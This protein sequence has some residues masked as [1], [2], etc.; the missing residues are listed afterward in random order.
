MID[1]RDA[2]AV[3]N[4]LR[5]VMVT[6]LPVMSGGIADVFCSVSCLAYPWTTDFPGLA[7]PQC[8][9]R[10]T[11]LECLNGLIARPS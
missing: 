2:A 3:P 1:V 7:E 10:T 4:E 11:P 9:S 6:W 8:F 5:A